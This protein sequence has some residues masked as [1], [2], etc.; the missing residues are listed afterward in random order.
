MKP[1][2]KN[3]IFALAATGLLLASCGGSNPYS[4]PNESGDIPSSDASVDTQTAPSSTSVLSGPDLYW[5]EYADAYRFSESQDNIGLKITDAN[6][7]AGFE[8]QAVAEGEW[9]NVALFLEDAEA[10]IAAINVN[11]GLQ[12]FQASAS[13]GPATLGLTG[14]SLPDE[15]N[16]FLSDEGLKISNIDAYIDQ[17]RFYLNTQNV[18]MLTTVLNLLVREIS[19]DSTWKFPQRGYLD[20]SEDTFSLLQLAVSSLKSILGSSDVLKSVYDVDPALFIFSS[21]IQEDD[22][23]YTIKLDSADEE[24]LKTFALDIFDE[25]SGLISGLLPSDSEAE[26]E[27]ASEGDLR[28]TFEE[29]IDGLLDACEFG[30]FQ[31]TTTFCEYQGIMNQTIDFKIKSFDRDKIET[32]MN[33]NIG[34]L[35]DILGGLLGEEEEELTPEPMGLLGE[36]QAEEEETASLTLPIPYGEW[37]LSA[38]LD[39]TFGRR[40]APKTLTDA[41]KAKYATEITLPDLSGLFEGETDPSL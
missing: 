12:A 16:M 4:S 33:E 8:Y 38:S 5:K 30:R 24:D 31:Q 19:G 17:G 20:L 23:I 18:S 13:V 41:E 26:G 37:N 6:M 29:M 27:G 7:R 35:M 14:S 28:V 15:I 1:F 32:F 39:Y 11:S 21:N 9:D 36:E 34:P 25:F 2:K 40:V 3:A 22:I 10:E